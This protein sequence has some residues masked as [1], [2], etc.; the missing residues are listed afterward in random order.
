[1]IFTLIAR[2][3]ETR[4]IGYLYLEDLKRAGTP[5]DFSFLDP[6]FLEDWDDFRNVIDA[7]VILMEEVKSAEE[8]DELLYLAETMIE[9]KPAVNPR[10]DIIISKELNDYFDAYQEVYYM[11][12]D[13]PIYQWIIDNFAENPVSLEKLNEESLNYLSQE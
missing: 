12:D 5:E 13:L 11:E 8:K 4:H 2:N 1:M 3:G 9:F 10:I 6:V 7:K